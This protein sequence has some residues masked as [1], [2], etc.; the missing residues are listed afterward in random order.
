MD[1]TTRNA[2]FEAATQ[3]TYW[4]RLNIGLRTKVSH[5][6]YTYTVDVPSGDDPAQALITYREGY[7]GTEF[8]SEVATWAQTMLIVDTAMGALRVH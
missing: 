2:I 6:G 7:G 5:G 8:L 3:S 1:A 4:Q